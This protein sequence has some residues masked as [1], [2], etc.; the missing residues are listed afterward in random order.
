MVLL[1]ML[2]VALASAGVTF[3]LLIAVIA[4]PFDIAAT[5][6]LFVIETVLLLIFDVIVPAVGGAE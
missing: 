6:G 1:F 4:K 2:N 3:W 5:V